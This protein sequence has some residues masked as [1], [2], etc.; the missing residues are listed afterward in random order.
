[1]GWTALRQSVDRLL[2]FLVFPRETLFL[3]TMRRPPGW[4]NF[5]DSLFLYASA[6]HGGG[7]GWIVEIGSYKGLSTTYLALGTLSS[8][9]GRVLACDP[10]S[11]GTYDEFKKNMRS[12]GVEKTVEPA[13]MT[14]EKR[15][16]SWQEPVRFL[17][18]DGDH[19]KSGAQTD[20][21]LWSKHLVPGGI[22]AFH[23]Y[24]YEGPGGVFREEILSSPD[25]CNAGYLSNIAYASKKFC[26]NPKLFERFR[27][28][29]K[30]RA[31]FA[32][33]ARKRLG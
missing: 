31:P 19:S 10:H 1:M 25:F 20:V 28:L 29:E 33:W 2:G 30:I 17:W 8:N 21:R 12:F 26:T 6:K 22:I 11:E 4:I 23:D 18:I 32:L 14:S 5:A 24:A 9:G 3:S 27:F 13:V 16:A 7:K 15:A